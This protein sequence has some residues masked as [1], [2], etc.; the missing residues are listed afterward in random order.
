[1]YVMWCFTGVFVLVGCDDLC[2]LLLLI[3]S[4]I[5]RLALKTMLAALGYLR[6]IINDA[7]HCAESAFN[8]ETSMMLTSTPRVIRA[9][10]NP[11]IQASLALN[12][13]FSVHITPVL[14][15][16][17]PLHSHSCAE[18]AFLVYIHSLD[19][20]LHAQPIFWWI[21]LEGFA[22]Y[23]LVWL[24]LG[25]QRPLSHSHPHIGSCIWR[26]DAESPRAVV[27]IW[28]YCRTAQTGA[29]RAAS[30]FWVR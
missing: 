5:L 8:I 25:W 22:Y 27:H 12:A 19:P 4:D 18:S 30:Y 2:K 26:G 11:S 6:S 20:R 9:K 16:H 24:H 3:W 13:K 1:M 29:L 10:A 7:T 28:P 21:L 23:C 15:E 14:E 17:P